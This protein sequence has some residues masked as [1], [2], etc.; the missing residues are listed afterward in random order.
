ME[1][2]WVIDFG[3]PI[4]TIT[5]WYLTIIYYKEMDCVW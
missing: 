2:E 4:I 1:N 3:V 5:V